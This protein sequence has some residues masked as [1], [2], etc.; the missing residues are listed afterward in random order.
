MLSSH[1]PTC[2]AKLADFGLAQLIPKEGM[3]TQNLTGTFG[4]QAPEIVK[5]KPYGTSADIWQLGCL[6]FAMLTITLP[7]MIEDFDISNSASSSLLFDRVSQNIDELAESDSCKDLLKGMLAI[8]P[9]FRFTAEQV[10]EHPFF[11]N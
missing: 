3:V 2:V 8:N 10:L 11:D 4:Y 1:E 9:E 7:V 6:L 5:G